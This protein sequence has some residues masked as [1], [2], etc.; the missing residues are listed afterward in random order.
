MSRDEAEAVLKET[1]NSP[2][3][4]L[5]IEPG[6]SGQQIKQAFRKSIMKWHPDHN[7]N[8]E[9]LAAAMTREILAA[10]ELLRND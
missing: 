6:A 1:Q 2:W 7:A 8:G 5:G 3:S 10:Y 4:V 9:A